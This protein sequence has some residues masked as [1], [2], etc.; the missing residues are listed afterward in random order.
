M[1]FAQP[2]NITIWQM[3]PT[4]NL[5]QHSLA[6]INKIGSDAANCY[7][8]S[9]VEIREHAQVTKQPIGWGMS[10]IGQSLKI[11]DKY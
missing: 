8:N 4:L 11:K 1:G 10:R 7:E 3:Q 2:V 5:P 9:Q 6:S